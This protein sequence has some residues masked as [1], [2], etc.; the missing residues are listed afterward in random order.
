MHNFK[1]KRQCRPVSAVF[2]YYTFLISE[3]NFWGNQQY[4]TGKPILHKCVFSYTIALVS[5]GTSLFMTAAHHENPY[6]IMTLLKTFQVSD[7]R[8]SEG[9]IIAVQREYVNVARVLLHKVD[10]FTLETVKNYI[11][12]GWYSDPARDMIQNEIY[13]RY[14]NTYKT[15]K[16]E[17]K[18]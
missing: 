9:F 18:R 12:N 4:Y 16:K 14:S 8:M 10:L 7:R 15:N 2:L 13:F 11:D 5:S 1:H 17:I 3:Y 6:F